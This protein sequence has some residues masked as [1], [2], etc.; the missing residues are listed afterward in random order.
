MNRDSF[1]KVSYIYDFFEKNIIKDY[2]GS[3]E[4]IKENIRFKNSDLVI[5]VGGGTGYITDYFASEIKSGVVLDFSRNMLSKNKNLKF[6]IIEIDS[7]DL[8]NDNL[9]SRCYE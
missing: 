5:D 8:M 2:Q 9:Y 7:M 6:R 3:I 4:I 1:G